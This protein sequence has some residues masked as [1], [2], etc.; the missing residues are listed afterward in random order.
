MGPKQRYYENVAKTIIENL[1]K[2]IQV[3][4]SKIK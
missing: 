1:E 2:R 4:E 3:L